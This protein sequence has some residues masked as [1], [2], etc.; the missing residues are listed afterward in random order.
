MC[1]THGKIL[2]VTETGCEGIPDPKW[3][4]EVLSPAIKGF[5]V[6]YI[7]TWRNA[8]D[9]PGHYFAPF[10]GEASAPDFSQWTKTDHITLL[11]YDEIQ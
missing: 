3:W 2:A 10:K 8:S 5:P 1:R 7:L 4:T 11:Q 9:R 6:S